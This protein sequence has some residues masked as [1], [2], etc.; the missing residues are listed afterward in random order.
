[1]L[2]DVSEV[3]AASIIRDVSEAVHSLQIRPSYSHHK[4]IYSDTFLELFNDD[5]NF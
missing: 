4:M 5:Y 1:M 2:A 3:R